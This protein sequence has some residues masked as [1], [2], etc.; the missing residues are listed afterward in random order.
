MTAT[1]KTILSALLLAAVTPFA[2]AVEA[3]KVPLPLKDGVYQ[4]KHK[5]AEH[6]Q[7]DS[8]TLEASIKNGRISLVNKDRA[9][10]FPLGLIDEG[11]LVW[12]EKSQEW[13][14]STDPADLNAEDVG[15]CSDG[16]TVVDLKEKIYWTC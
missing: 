1:I 13:I 9:D 2:F 10:V 6:P 4:F 14:I 7:M 3:G 5:F 15:G 11:E 12:H 16:P 8:I